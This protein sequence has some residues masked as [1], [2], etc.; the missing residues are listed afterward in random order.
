MEDLDSDPRLMTPPL[1]SSCGDLEDVFMPLL[2]LLPLLLPDFGIWLPP[3]T[4]QLMAESRVAMDFS[5]EM[6]WEEE[7]P[8]EEEP[9]SLTCQPAMGWSVQWAVSSSADTQQQNC[10][11]PTSCERVSALA[12]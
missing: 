1:E 5:E 10:L 12:G 4:R 9:D 6:Q 7:V 11:L 8:L 3:T 2:P